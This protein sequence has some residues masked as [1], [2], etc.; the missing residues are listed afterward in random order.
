[1]KIVLRW[2]NKIFRIAVYILCCLLM[3]MAARIANVEFVY[4]GY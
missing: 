4:Q 2:E 3:L 1:M